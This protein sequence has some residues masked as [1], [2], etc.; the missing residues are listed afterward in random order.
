MDAGTPNL[1]K[2]R[3]SR[4]LLSHF[5]LTL[6]V[7]LALSFVTLAVV[8]PATQE[9][10]AVIPLVAIGAGMLIGGAIVALADYIWD[11]RT[12]DPAG[13]TQAEYA[14]WIKT[15][16]ELSAGTA[17]AWAQSD[18]ENMDALTYLWARQG[19]WG[20]RQL[21]ISQKESNTTT[22]YSMAESFEWPSCT[23][24]WPSSWGMARKCTI[25]STAPGNPSV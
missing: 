15:V 5:T 8:G 17:K 7:L 23:A 1:K 16:V 12:H 25:P 6:S 10:D 9:A 3:I 22:I 20:A 2:P 24:I 19:E 13:L 4:R 21:F 18:A 14:T 11:E